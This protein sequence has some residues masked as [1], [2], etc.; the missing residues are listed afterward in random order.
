VEQ[1]VGNKVLLIMVAEAAQE[2]LLEEAGM[3]AKVEMGVL[4]EAAE[5]ALTALIVPMALVMVHPVLSE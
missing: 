5:A 4:M 2:A 3:E 1:L